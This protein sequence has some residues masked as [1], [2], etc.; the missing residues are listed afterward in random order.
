MAQRRSS[1]REQPSRERASANVESQNRATNDALVE[2]LGRRVALPIQSVARSNATLR[3]APG[4]TLPT[5]FGDVPNGLAV[6]DNIDVFV[7]FDAKG[8]AVAS[9]TVPL[10]VRGEVRFLEVVKESADG[11]AWVD[12]GLPVPLF[13]PK[14]EQVTRMRLGSTH[15]IALVRGADGTL[16]GTT[17]V[18]ELLHLEPA[19]FEP[20][21]WVPGEAWRN[22]PTIGLFAILAGK[23]VGRV[24]PSEPHQQ[25][26]GQA[27]EYRISK[28]LP[29]GKLE[30][31]LRATIPSALPLDVE[32]VLATLRENPRLRVGD[33]TSPEQVRAHFGLS[34]KAFKRAL[35][36]LFKRGQIEFD[37]K[38]FA[39]VT[40]QA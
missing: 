28:V 25:Q 21:E 20:G 12:W 29:D 1:P 16:I 23:W 5:A 26:R 13:V 18:T 40:A 2:I 31:S 19:P 3:V 10:L 37:A 34:K 14:H 38:G 30:V 22:E 27:S 4:V 35:G 39:R 32:H 11:G 36:V 6:G 8:L 7:C 9:L 15:P 33:D 24:P 17:Q